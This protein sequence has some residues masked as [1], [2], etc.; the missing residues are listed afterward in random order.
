[1]YTINRNGEE[2]DVAKGLMIDDEFV[3]PLTFDE[4]EAF[5]NVWCTCFN[6]SRTSST[7]RESAGQPTRHLLKNH[8][9]GNKTTCL[10]STNED[11]EL[12]SH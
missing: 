2:I 3:Q 6:A 5:K 12:I 8:A 4:I 7:S 1:M 10:M 11:I 9:K